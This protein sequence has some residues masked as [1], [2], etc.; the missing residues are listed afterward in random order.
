MKIIS[1]WYSIKQRSHRKTTDAKSST[2][3]LNIKPRSI[4]KRL[5]TS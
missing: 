4:L 2:K 1:P 3:Y 5:Y